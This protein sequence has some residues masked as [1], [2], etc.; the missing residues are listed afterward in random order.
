VTSAP[1][2]PVCTALAWG[3]QSL[4]NH[5]SI[6]HSNLTMVKVLG[7]PGV[8]VVVTTICEVRLTVPRTKHYM[9]RVHLC[10]LVVVNLEVTPAEVDVLRMRGSRQED[11]EALHVRRLKTMTD[12]RARFVP[13]ANLTSGI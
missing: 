13:Q 8:D 9:D 3:G 1:L 5:Q 11:E 6:H 4:A 12:C 7:V 2:A 10:R